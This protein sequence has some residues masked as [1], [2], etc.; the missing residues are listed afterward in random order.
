MPPLS[1]P[2]RLIVAWGDASHLLL[3]PACGYRVA[4][5]VQCQTTGKN[6][7]SS[8]N[9]RPAGRRLAG[10][11]IAGALAFGAASC[12]DDEEKDSGSSETS[13]EES[14]APEIDPRLLDD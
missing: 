9:G 13:S 7:R 10:I 12:G 6:M 1:G 8:K 14:A 4:A 3:S 2:E 5:S 11:V